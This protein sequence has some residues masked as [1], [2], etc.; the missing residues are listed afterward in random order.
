MQTK[1]LPVAEMSRILNTTQFAVRRLIRSQQ[2]RAVKV[3]GQWRVLTADVQEFLDTMANRPSRLDSWSPN[4]ATET[5]PV[6][7]T[8]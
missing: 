7:E 1:S 6:R 5:S 8:I 2:L 4:E 3:G